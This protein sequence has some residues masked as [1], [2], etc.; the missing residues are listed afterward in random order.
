ME[1]LQTGAFIQ[2]GLQARFHFYVRLSRMKPRTY[3]RF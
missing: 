1:A 2:S 3:Y